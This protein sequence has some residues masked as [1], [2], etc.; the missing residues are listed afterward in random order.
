MTESTG[1]G[2]STL[3]LKPMVQS[4]K[5]W[6]REYQWLHKMVTLWPQ[7]KPKKTKKPKKQQQQRQN[8]S[9]FISASVSAHQPNVSQLFPWKHL[10]LGLLTADLTWHFVHSWSETFSFCQHFRLGLR[11]IMTPLPFICHGLAFVQILLPP[12]I[13]V[14]FISSDCNSIYIWDKYFTFRTVWV[15]YTQ[16]T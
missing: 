13:I 16:F 3:A 2:A 12:M 1:D 4:T 7:K 9:H 14:P 8:A 11:K 10:F 5:V 15:W 6:N